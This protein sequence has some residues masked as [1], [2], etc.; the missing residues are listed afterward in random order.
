M[1]T[2]TRTSLAV[3]AA[4]DAVWAVLA[5]VAARPQWHPGLTWARLDGPLAVGT[6]GA[7]KPER[8]RPVAV[9]VTELVPGCRLVL[10]GTHGP[11]VA[12]GH[13]EHEVVPD[14]AGGSVLTHSMALSGLLARPIARFFSRPLGVSASEEALRAVARLAAG[15]AGDATGEQASADAPPGPAR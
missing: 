8:A 15:K 7:W 6:R 4:P 3:D 12:R 1:V 14:G 2:L 13:Y 9:E 10:Q 11:A 5:D